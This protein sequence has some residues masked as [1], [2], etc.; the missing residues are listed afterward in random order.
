MARGFL[1]AEEIG[2]LQPERHL[3]VR[4]SIEN[5]CNDFFRNDCNLNLHPG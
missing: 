3:K 4:N 5:N 1:N 2:K